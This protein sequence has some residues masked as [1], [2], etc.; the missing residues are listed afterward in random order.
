MQC[1]VFPSHQ[2]RCIPAHRGFD[3]FSAENVLENKK[4]PICD[5]YV[6]VLLK[7]IV[8]TLDSQLTQRISERDLLIQAM[9]MADQMTEMHDKT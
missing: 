1:F 4:P 3:Q 5:H 6:R 7:T 2:G 9:P 8:R